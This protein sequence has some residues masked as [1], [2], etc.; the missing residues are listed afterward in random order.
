MAVHFITSDAKSLLDNFNARI[1]QKEATGKVTTWERSEDGNY[2]T[3]KAQDWNRKAW[4]RPKIEKNQ[5]TFNLI[6]PKGLGISVTVYAYY[7][8]HMLETFLNHFD[9][10]FENGIVTALPGPG[11]NV[12]SK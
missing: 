9:K 11:D 5:L 6:R 7:H 8:G 3:H 2:Y 10:S 4:F 1:D 12:T